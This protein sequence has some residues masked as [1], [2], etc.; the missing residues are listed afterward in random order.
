ME[1]E[2]CYPL[3]PDWIR[4]LFNND[5]SIV[6]LATVSLD[7]DNKVSMIDRDDVF[8]IDYDAVKD[9]IMKKLRS[10]DS[11]F[12]MKTKRIG[13]LVWCEFKNGNLL[14]ED[15]N[16]CAEKE[17]ELKEKI[18]DSIM[19][20]LSLVKNNTNIPQL[21]YIKSDPIKYIKEHSC[22]YLVYNEDKNIEKTKMLSHLAANAG[23]SEVG[24]C[25]FSRLKNKFVGYLH[26]EMMSLTADEFENKIDEYLKASANSDE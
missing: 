8:V 19:I 14:D 13:D 17:E 20:F 16:L 25:G 6:N 24:L 4:E 23:E 11:F 12:V 3:I 7:T 9:T 1:S 22:Y 2:R 5:D 18:Y 10:N 21:E 15:G 26:R